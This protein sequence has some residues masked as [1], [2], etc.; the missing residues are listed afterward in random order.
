MNVFKSP[1]E[2]LYTWFGGLDSISRSKDNLQDL[3]N[4]IV[5]SLNSLSYVKDI[6]DLFEEPP[7][8]GGFNPI[9]FSIRLPRSLQ[10]HVKL[11]ESIDSGAEEFHLL[12]DGIMLMISAKGKGLLRPFGVYTAREILMEILSS[13]SVPKRIPPCLTFNAFVFTQ[14]TQE[15]RQNPVDLYIRTKDSDVQLKD[16]LRSFYI[17]FASSMHNF[18]DACATADDTKRLLWDLDESEEDLL[19]TLTKFVGVDWHKIL[20]SRELAKK[21]R[22]N[23]LK[24]IES[25]NK[26]TAML[27]QLKV[28]HEPLAN[29]MARNP[30]FSKF[31]DLVDWRHYA[32]VDPIDREMYLRSI[33]QARSEIE[34]YSV[35]RSTLVSALVGAIVGSIV[36]LVVAYVIG[37]PL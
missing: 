34:T 32:D 23:I 33:E 8:L 21:I 18:Y 13:T 29:D 4:K 10:K 20:E 25:L 3:R 14:P 1:D 11:F 24:V 27:R 6:E 31:M 2:V 26:Y 7:H 36:T 15:I 9:L 35:T 12:Y 16:L 37:L 30:N 28:K 5:R 22:K 19:S 17:E